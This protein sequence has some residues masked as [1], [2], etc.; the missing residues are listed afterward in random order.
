MWLNIANCTFPVAQ[1]PHPLGPSDSGGRSRSPSGR[2][3]GPETGTGGR[4]PD[5]LGRAG[6]RGARDGIGPDRA[7]AVASGRERIGNRQRAREAKPLSYGPREEARRQPNRRRA[8]QHLCRFGL[9]V[10]AVGARGSLLSRAAD[11]RGMR[12]GRG[13]AA[14]YASRV[15]APSALAALSASL[16]LCVSASRGVGPRIPGGRAPLRLV[17]TR[18]DSELRCRLGRSRS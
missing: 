14:M 18:L 10:L 4:Q 12:S 9:V 5:R 15:F 17:S 3:R 8:F 1:R 16:H 6:M 7:S 11:R 13:P 2:G